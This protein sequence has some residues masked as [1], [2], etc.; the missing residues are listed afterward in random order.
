MKKS[1]PI[2]FILFFIFFSCK[3]IE[4]EVVIDDA[5]KTYLTGILDKMKLN[6]LNRNQINWDDFYKNVFEKAKTAK[7]IYEQ[8]VTEAIS[9][10]LTQLNDSG[11]SYFITNS[12][13]FIVGS[14]RNDCP[15]LSIGTFSIPNNIGYV[16]VGSFSGSGNVANSFAEQIQ[17]DIKK[18]DKAS[19]IGWIVDLRGNTGGNMW[20]MVAGLEPLIGEGIIG[21]FIDNEGNTLPWELFNGKTSAVTVSLPYKLINQKIKIAVLTDQATAS[22]G[23]ATA[24]A[25]KG[26]ENAKSFGTNTCGISTAVQG[27]SFLDGSTL[28][29][30]VS[31]MAD[32]NKKIYG[33]VVIPDVVEPDPQKQIQ[34]ASAWILE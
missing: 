27:F 7:N 25:F 23:E 32:K 5:V 14:G 17:N 22:S 9:L 18:Q 26:L 20:P 19:L 10:A 29:L 2:F 28:G 30:V 15:A 31:N 4:K 34:K 11:H 16:K 13:S 6:S 1:L 8:P 21:Y 3:K 33:K 24:I 12:G